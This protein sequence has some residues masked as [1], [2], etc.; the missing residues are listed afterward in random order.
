MERPAVAMFAQ[1]ILLKDLIHRMTDLVYVID[2]NNIW[3]FLLGPCKLV[4]I[5]FTVSN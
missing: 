1:F 4:Y 5:L 2:V 3:S